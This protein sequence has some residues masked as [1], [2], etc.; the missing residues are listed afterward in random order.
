MPM[1]S[2]EILRPTP[3]RP[4]DPVDDFD[5]SD[6]ALNRFLA[7]FAL[8]SELSHASRTYVAVSEGKIA[9]YYSLTVT[10][11]EYEQGS[12]RLQKGLVQ[13][14]IPMILLARLAGDR[15]FQGQGLGA[16]LL[17]DAMLRAISV[18]DQAGVRGVLVHA[19]DDAARR[20]Y[21]RFDFEPLP[22]NELHLVMLMKDLKRIVGWE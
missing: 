19:K 5:C 12:K 4:E 2:S 9:G 8:T 22:G 7:K 3:L 10:S 16:E 13:Y 15:R 17:R 21:E 18:S 1:S 20:F 6:L 14:P 11:L